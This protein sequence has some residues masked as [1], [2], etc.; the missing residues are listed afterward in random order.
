M[1]ARS[2]NYI[3]FSAIACIIACVGEFLSLFIFGAFYPGYSQLKETMSSLGAS[4]S[5]VSNEISAWW[6]IMGLLIIFF[7]IG[8]KESFSE[9]RKKATIA[10]WLIILYG[11]GEGIGSGMFKADH[12]LNN[13]TNSGIL[14]DI[15]GGIG[16]TAILALPLVMVRVI[17]KKENLFFYR[18]SWI[19][20]FG[21]IVAVILFA[22]RFSHNEN[23]FLTLYK[24]LWQR[25]FML[26]TYIYLTTISIIIIKKQH[27]TE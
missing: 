24:G 25:L 8:V 23:N 13:L 5:P 18:L 3:T 11:F 17:T 9:K 12:V 1:M 10:S 14:H 6:V 22:F 21:G 19:V 2:A 4:V 7:G 26:N 20:F 27:E 16:V 15:L